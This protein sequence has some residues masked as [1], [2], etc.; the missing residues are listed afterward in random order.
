MRLIFIASSIIVTG[1]AAYI[2]WRTYIKEIIRYP[3]Q[4]FLATVILVVKLIFPHKYELELKLIRFLDD[5]VQANR[6]GRTWIIPT[7]AQDDMNKSI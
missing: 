2:Y 4:Y 1:I 5:I 7:K 3:R 6:T